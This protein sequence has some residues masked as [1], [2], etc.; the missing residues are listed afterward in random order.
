[1]SSVM[2]VYSPGES[3]VWPQ[4]STGWIETAFAG[5]DGIFLLMGP[6]TAT[7]ALLST[8]CLAG[9]RLLIVSSICE[10]LLPLVRLAQRP[11]LIPLI[12]H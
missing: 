1:M 10:T 11:R 3:Q 7:E 2:L 5:V 6:P 8:G 9:I 4:Y 12:E